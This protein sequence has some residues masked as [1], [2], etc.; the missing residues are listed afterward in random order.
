MGRSRNSTCWISE[1]VYAFSETSKSIFTDKICTGI[2]LKRGKRELGRKNWDV[3]WY[4]CEWWIR[5]FRLLMSVGADF[6]GYGGHPAGYVQNYPQNG[7]K[8]KKLTNFGGFMMFHDVL[9]LSYALSLE[10]SFPTV[11]ILQKSSKT[12]PIFPFTLLAR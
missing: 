12:S 7:G 2:K 1:P 3:Y 5:L 11:V 4:E 8:R 10:K 9:S 6:W